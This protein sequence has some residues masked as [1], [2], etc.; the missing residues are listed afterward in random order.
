MSIKIYAGY[1]RKRTMQ[2]EYITLLLSGYDIA[3]FG[4]FLVS[5]LI[6]ISGKIHLQ[7]SSRGFREKEIQ[8]SHIGSTPR[9]GGIAVLFGC[10]FAWYNSDNFS[11]NFLGLIILSGVP[12]LYLDCLTIYILT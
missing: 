12:V 10:T 2:I 3:L 1:T 9:I 7:Y 11:S 6:I 8:R 4:S 5:I